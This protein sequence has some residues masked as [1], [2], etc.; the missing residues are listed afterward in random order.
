MHRT[1]QCRVGLGPPKK[2]LQLFPAFRNK[3]APRIRAN[4]IGI[5]FQPIYRH[6]PNKKQGFLLEKY[7]IAQNP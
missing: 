4:L 3:N 2:D 5:Q 7:V 6:F 1:N